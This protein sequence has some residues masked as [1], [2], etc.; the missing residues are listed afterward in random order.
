MRG[1]GVMGFPG[2]LGCQ[3]C[4]AMRWGDGWGGREGVIGYPGYSGYWVFMVV[5]L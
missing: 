4:G 5:G 2:Y 1:K 3:R